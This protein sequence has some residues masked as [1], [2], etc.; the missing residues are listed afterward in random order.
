MPGFVVA[1]SVEQMPYFREYSHTVYKIYISFTSH[2]LKICLILDSLQQRRKT[3]A[4]E[5][6]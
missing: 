3:K 4:E 5:A 1:E 2:A 6:N